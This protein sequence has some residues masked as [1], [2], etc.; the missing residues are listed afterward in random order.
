MCS[1]PTTATLNLVQNYFLKTHTEIDQK[2]SYPYNRIKN[3]AN[4]LLGFFPL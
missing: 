1:V 4:V 3:K 2:I